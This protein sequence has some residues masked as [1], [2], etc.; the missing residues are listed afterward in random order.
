[1]AIGTRNDEPQL[2]VIFEKLVTNI[3][4]GELQRVFNKW[5][6]VKNEVAFDYSLLWKILFSIF[7]IGAGFL[8]H[9]LKLRKLN[10]KLIRLSSTDQLTGISNRFKMNEFLNEHKSNTDR[11]KTDA[12]IILLDID[13]FKEVNDRFGHPTGDA[14]LVEFANTIK[15]NIRLTDHVARWGGEEFLIACPN[16]NIVDA[17]ALANKLINK[18]RKHSF[19][20][21]IRIT[22]SAG[23]SMLS[24]NHSVKESISNADKA[25]YE[26]KENGRDRV[27]VEA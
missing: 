14:V 16:I 4:Q 15:H 1:L 24:K 17:E 13:L 19:P 12:S 10:T 7:L 27:T 3:N 22:T 18:V 25:L 5:V 2:H 11:Y 26:S 6:S 8:L 9:Y 23:V 20:D 21:G